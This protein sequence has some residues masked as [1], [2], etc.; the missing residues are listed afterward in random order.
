[1]LTLALSVLALL[2]LAPGQLPDKLLCILMVCY[3]LLMVSNQPLMV[4]TK[5]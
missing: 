1:M 2:I 3:Q 5:P 4:S